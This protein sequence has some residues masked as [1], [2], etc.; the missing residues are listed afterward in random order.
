MA[1][2][3]HT[4]IEGDGPAQFWRDGCEQ[5]LEQLGDAVGG[6]AVWP[7]GEDDARGSFVDGEDELSVSCE[8]HEV[9]FPVPWR[10]PIGGFGGSL[11]DRDSGLDVVR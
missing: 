6:F 3:L 2:E 4:I 10:M 7:C 9:G 8:H 5:V 11:C 1:R